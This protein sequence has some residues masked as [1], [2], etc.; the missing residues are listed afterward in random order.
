MKRRIA[1]TAMVLVM[2]V[3]AF[4]GCKAKE[5]EEKVIRV[6]SYNDGILNFI[7]VEPGFAIGSKTFQCFFV[8]V[9]KPK[10]TSVGLCC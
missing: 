7:G 4:G 9:F 10:N 6:M 8:S 2:L 5:P 1:A 3:C